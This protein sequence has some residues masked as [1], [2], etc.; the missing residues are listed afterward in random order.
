MHRTSLRDCLEAGRVEDEK[1]LVRKV[2]PHL[3]QLLEFQAVRVLSDN[4]SYNI[5]IPNGILNFKSVV[6]SKSLLLFCFRIDSGL[7]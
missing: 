2:S 6:N 4:I 5:F 1:H 3:G 7:F